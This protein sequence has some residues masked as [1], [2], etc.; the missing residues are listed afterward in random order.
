MRHFFYI[1][2]LTWLLLSATACDKSSGYVY[3]HSLSICPIQATASLDYSNRVDYKLSG[4]NIHSYSS[5][6]VCFRRVTSS[7]REKSYSEIVDTRQNPNT[8]QT[9]HTYQKLSYN[10]VG[11]KVKW[12]EL[13]T[14]STGKTEKYVNYH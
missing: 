8:Y 12:I 11:V 4:Y 9:Y 6:T 2:A 3:D 7:G 10:E 5:C 14:A 1:I 13:T